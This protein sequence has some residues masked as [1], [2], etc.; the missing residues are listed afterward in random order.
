MTIHPES[1]PFAEPIGDVIGKGKESI[2]HELGP[3]WVV[4]EFNPLDENGEL[5][6]PKSYERSQSERY[7]KE[8]QETQRVLSQDFVFGDKLLPIQWVLGTDEKGNPKYFTLQKRIESNTLTNT[9]KNGR[10]EIPDEEF[11]RRFKLLSETNPVF[12]EEML[13][14]VWGAKRALI[15]T[16]VFYDFH[17]G[18]I[19]V[20]RDGSLKIIDLPNMVHSANLVYS[21][22]DK[23][24]RA[25]HK[26]LGKVEKHHD[27]LQ[28]FEKWLEVTP[29][30][31]EGL[32][33]KFGTEDNKYEDVVTHLRKM[34]DN[35]PE[36]KTEKP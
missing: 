27:R 9:I 31:R 32:D 18:N 2:V 14:L 33:N 16:G 6:D 8:Y 34:R 3:N 15:E 25:K 19:A 21:E 23:Y 26:I 5:K 35:L 29:S 1:Y 28:D 13:E 4:K 17:P 30:E 10:D 20:Q 24:L 7:I 22:G 36:L 11:I 12:R